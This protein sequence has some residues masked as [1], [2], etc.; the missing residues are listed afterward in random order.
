MKMKMKRGK[1]KKEDNF[2]PYFWPVSLMNMNE[3]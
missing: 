1:W 2:K 3:R